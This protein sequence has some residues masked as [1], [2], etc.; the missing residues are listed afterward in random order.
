MAQILAAS[1]V[2]SGID[3]CCCNGAG[4]LNCHFKSGFIPLC[5]WAEYGDPSVPPNFYRRKLITGTMTINRFSAAGCGGAATMPASLSC[6]TRGGTASLIGYS[7]FTGMDYPFQCNS[8]GISIPPRKYRTKTYSGSTLYVQYGGPDYCTPGSSCAAG[9]E[10]SRDRYDFTGVD[11]WPVGGGTETVGGTR[12][13]YS[14][15]GPCP[16]SPVLSL[17]STVPANTATPGA[18]GMVGFVIGACTPTSLSVFGDGICHTGLS[19]GTRMATGFSQVSLSDEDTDTDAKTRLLAGAGGTWSGYAAAD[20]PTCRAAWQVRTGFG[21]ITFEYR[22]LRFK[23]TAGGLNPSTAYAAQVDVMQRAYGVGSY[24]KLTTL[25]VNGTTDG[26]GN[27]TI[28]NQVVADYQG[29]ESYVTNAVVLLT[30][31]IVDT[32]NRQDDYAQNFHSVGPATCDLTETDASTRLAYGVVDPA[33]P[34]MADYTGL[35]TITQT[36]VTYNRTGSGIC[37][38]APRYGGD[39][40]PYVK[41]TGTVTESLTNQDKPLDAVARDEAGKTWQA[42]EL[43]CSLCSAFTIQSNNSGQVFYRSV[44]VQVLATALTPLANYKATI[45]LQARV[46][47]TATPWEPYDFIEISFTN[48]SGTTFI[49]SFQPLPGL[50]GI[51]GDAIEVA[52]TSV[53]LTSQP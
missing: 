13:Y 15:S 37:L 38:Y 9:G 51:V 30:A 47:G 52:A 19:Y 14:S 46:W 28:T 6:S 5:G 22:Q 33:G 40:T 27:L 17:I 41:A 23:L 35:V 39:P 4:T 29:M 36:P 18:P 34:N 21:Q 8:G 1:I 45:Y 25:T 20:L 53:V 11:S 12:K 7:E 32:W 50:P 44:E 42:C 48:G 26:S 43:G 16:C 2:G 3:P 31:S 10:F 49:T 24:T